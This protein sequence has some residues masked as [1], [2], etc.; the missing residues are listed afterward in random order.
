VNIDTRLEK[1]EQ[2]VGRDPDPAQPRITFIVV[3]G[4][5]GAGEET[6]ETWRLVDGGFVKDDGRDCDEWIK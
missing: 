5:R 1:L 4:D 2:E 3:R 6:L